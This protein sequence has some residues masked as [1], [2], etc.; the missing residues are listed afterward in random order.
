MK[1]D[2]EKLQYLIFL[3]R[4]CSGNHTYNQTKP[5]LQYP[6]VYISQLFFLHQ[7]VYFENTLL[8]NQTLLHCFKTEIEVSLSFNHKWYPNVLKPDKI[9]TKCMKDVLI[10]SFKNFPEG[11]FSLLLLLRI[12][13]YFACEDW[14]WDL[15]AVFYRITRQKQSKVQ[16]TL[17]P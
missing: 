14:R 13:E 1:K 8:T 15:A 5:R 6:S 9:W 10:A 3:E 7:H 2:F 4:I 12:S 17:Q 11:L 16:C